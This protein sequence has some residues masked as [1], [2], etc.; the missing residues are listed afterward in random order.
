MAENGGNLTIVSRA[1]MTV[2]CNADVA[3]VFG[4]T[5]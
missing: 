4:G 2:S 3:M 1:I 5:L